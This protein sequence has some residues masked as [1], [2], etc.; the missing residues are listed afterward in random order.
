MIPMLNRDTSAGYM[1]HWAARLFAKAIDRRLKPLGLSSGQLSVFFALDGGAELSQADLTRVAATEQPTMAATLT[2]MK[3]D[4]LI[5]RKQD[6]SHGRRMLISL[7]SK[8]ARK[9]PAIRIAVSAV[10]EAALANMTA[11]EQNAFL[12]LTARAI[13]S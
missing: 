5:I 6:P 8:A 12:A 1:T 4:G 9:M 3:R 11:D 2:R 7:T 13:K 10:N